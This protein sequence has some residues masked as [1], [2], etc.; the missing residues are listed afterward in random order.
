M[1][2]SFICPPYFY[3]NGFIGYEPITVTVSDHLG[4]QVGHQSLHSK[5][6][7]TLTVPISLLSSIP[8]LSLSPL[9]FLLPLEFSSTLEG[10]GHEGVYFKSPEE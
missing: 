7:V 5:D 9:V 8:V 2:T 1:S 10:F 6:A 4:K 3:F